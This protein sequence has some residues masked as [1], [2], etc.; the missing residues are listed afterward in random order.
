MFTQRFDENLG[1]AGEPRRAIEAV[2][3]DVVVVGSNLHF[4]YARWSGGGPFEEIM[5]AFVGSLVSPARRRVV[6]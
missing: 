2:V 1:T 6:R 5:R 3:S 4:G